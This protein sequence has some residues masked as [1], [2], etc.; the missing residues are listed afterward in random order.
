[1]VVYVEWHEHIVTVIQRETSIKRWPRRW[2]L[3]LIDTQ[4]PAWQDLYQ[5]LLA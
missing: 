5:T 1:M 3:Y 4:N 2:K